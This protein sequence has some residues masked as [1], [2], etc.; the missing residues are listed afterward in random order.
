M[1]KIK[2]LYLDKL[3]EHMEKMIMDMCPEEVDL[4]FYQPVNGPKG[5]LED[6]EIESLL[7]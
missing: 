1:K 2:M 3:N 5:E 7:Y 4:R 6:A